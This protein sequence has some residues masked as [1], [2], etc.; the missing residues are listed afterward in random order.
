L[1]NGA[2]EKEVP[3]N[4]V[5]E[6]YF[7]ITI[8]ASGKLVLLDKLL[9]KLKADGH[10]VL[11]FSQ[12][13]R[14]LDILEEYCRFRAHQYE[15]LDGGVTGNDRQA[16]IDRFC[17]KGSSRFVFLLSTRAGGVG[18]NL[19]AADTV[20]I[21][22]SDWNPQQDIQAQAR[23]H[24]IGQKSN[25][26]VYRLVTRNTYESQMFE[27]ASRKLGLNNAVL[28]DLERSDKQLNNEEI[29]QM[30]R[31]GA[32]GL[33]QDDEES[34]KKFCEAD[35][36][37][38]LA[39][40]TRVVGQPENKSGSGGGGGGGDDEGTGGGGADDATSSAKKPRLLSGLNF[41]K[42]RF[43][44]ENADE[45][46]DVNDPDFWDKFLPISES[47]RYSADHLL[48]T[49]TDGSALI[50]ESTRDDFYETLQECVRR[51]LKTRDEVENP[52]DT[53]T[54]ISLLI[55]FSTMSYFPQ[56]QRSKAEKWLVEVEKRPERK[57][58][59]RGRFEAIAK[60]SSPPRPKPRGRKGAGSPAAADSDVEEEEEE[61]EDEGEGEGEGEGEEA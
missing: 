39:Q 22:D 46:I 8:Q 47:E 10:R 51:F 49:L 7:R 21:Y 35:I 16:A 34:A 43:S 53:D 17:R 41:S 61:E 11:I 54:V 59:Q 42:M 6:E 3:Q 52:P 58:R 5:D 19:A 20:I 9:P 24:R 13:K 30:L 55:Q 15:R 26:M 18:L 1:I 48:A 45:G 12:M 2:E 38:I 29:D 36:D 28:N 25:V 60:A 57:S 37:T 31:L 44:S 50:N 23:C 33:I 56:S 32:Y 40:N 27:R 14:V 4:I